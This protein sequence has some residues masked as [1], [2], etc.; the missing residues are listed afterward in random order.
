[1]ASELGVQTI[2]HTNGTDAM[3]IDSS[4]RLRQP[5]K[6][7][8]AGRMGGVTTVTASAAIKFDE[9]FVDQGGITY[10]TS[11]GKFT[12]PVDGIYRLTLNA[13]TNNTAGTRVRLYVNGTGASNIYGH[14]YSGDSDHQH[15]A[16]NSVLDL[17]ANDFIYFWCENG[18]VYSQPTDKFTEFSIE[19]IA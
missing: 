17:N 10:T 2:Q 19:M 3:T 7:I 11:N 4:G 9:F 14:T 6:P 1:M 18:A 5:A 13:L 12:V 15:L 16:I 8:I